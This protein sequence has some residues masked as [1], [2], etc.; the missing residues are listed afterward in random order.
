M[1]HANERAASARPA[2]QPS[3]AANPLR[4][5]LRAVIVHHGS[6]TGGHYTAFCR[7]DET[8]SA[9]ARGCWVHVS[10]EDVRAATASQVLSCEAYM[11]FYTQQRGAVGSE[12]PDRRS[13]AI[14]SAP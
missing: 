9:G 13:P 6:A 3:R 8:A 10:D 7:V 2:A 12:E 11:L 4:Y 5:D 14:V 1:P